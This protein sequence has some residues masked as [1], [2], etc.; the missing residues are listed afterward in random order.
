MTMHYLAR[1]IIQHDNK[2]LC[3]KTKDEDYHFLP[4]GH[5][6]FGESAKDA[7]QRE[8]Q[9]E[10][11]LQSNVGSFLGAVEHVWPEDKKNHHE[12]NLLFGVVLENIDSAQPPVSK[13]A[14]LEFCWVAISELQNVNMQPSPLIE[15]IAQLRDVQNNVRSIWGSTI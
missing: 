12:I 13:E 3:V 2:V 11:G 4:G 14:H 9:E 8:I 5:I 1:A 6:E 15:L 7:L 10:L